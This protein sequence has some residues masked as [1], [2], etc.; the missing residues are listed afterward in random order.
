MLI[1]I[2]MAVLLFFSL[3][4]RVYFQSQLERKAKY[5]FSPVL[6]GMILLGFLSPLMQTFGHSVL[7]LMMMSALVILTFIAGRNGLTDHGVL[8]PNL[9]TRL[10]DFQKIIKVNLQPVDVDQERNVIVSTFVE[11]KSQ[12]QHALVFEMSLNDLI[13]FLQQKLPSEAQI[14]K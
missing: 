7:F 1:I 8:L 13:S 2:V 3:V 10:L 14:E 5:N 12:R 6:G 4:R 11:K 9:L